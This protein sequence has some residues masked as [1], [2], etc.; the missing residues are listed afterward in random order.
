MSSLLDVTLTIENPRA[1][2]LPLL[3]VNGNRLQGSID[4]SLSVC[5]CVRIS[6][7]EL[8]VLLAFFDFFLVFL[9][10]WSM[11]YLFL[12][13]CFITVVSNQILLQAQNIR[14]LLMVKNDT[15]LRCYSISSIPKMF[16]VKLN[17]QWTLLIICCRNL[18]YSFF[19]FYRKKILKDRQK[20][21]NSYCKKCN[22]V[23]FPQAWEKL[24]RVVDF[25]EYAGFIFGIYSV[26]MWKDGWFTGENKWGKWIA[27]GTWLVDAFLNWNNDKDREKICRLREM[28]RF[29][30]V[31]W[32]VKMYG[33]CY[34]HHKSMHMLP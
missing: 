34:G 2:A 4:P 25:F 18:V 16:L 7:D 13:A 24:L 11:I 15:G 6:L 19:F 3:H 32:W 29:Y 22:R 12:G 10:A 17:L 28:E 31:V 8:E 1:L 33:I 27:F 21:V 23:S 20:M 5:M 30:W 14:V 9:F 26:C